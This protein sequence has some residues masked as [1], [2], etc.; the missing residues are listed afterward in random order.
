MYMG[1]NLAASPYVITLCCK[2]AICPWHCIH[3]LQNHT[4]DI[5]IY[6]NS[7]NCILVR[8]LLAHDDC[9]FGGRYYLLPTTTKK[10]CS[11]CLAL[12]PAGPSPDS[13]RPENPVWGSAVQKKKRV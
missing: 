6:L 12:V 10:A 2:I 11:L 13:H 5:C 7:L 3:R 4:T 8:S 1:G 9:C